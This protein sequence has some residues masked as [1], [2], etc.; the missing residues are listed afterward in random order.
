MSGKITYYGF[1]ADNFTVSVLE[2]YKK[3][4]ELLLTEP[5]IAITTGLL[6]GPQFLLHG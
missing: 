3:M 4:Q 5:L 1:N 2:V 6:M